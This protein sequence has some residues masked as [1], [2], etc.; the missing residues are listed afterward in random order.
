MQFQLSLDSSLPEQREIL[1]VRL[2]DKLIDNLDADDRLYPDGQYGLISADVCGNLGVEGF[3][4]VF[5]FGVGQFVE[6]G[7]SLLRV[8]VVDMLHRYFSFYS[9]FVEMGDF[10]L[11]QFRGYPR[12]AKRKNWFIVLKKSIE[13]ISESANA[14]E[15]VGFPLF[16][17]HFLVEQKLGQHCL[18]FKRFFFHNAQQRSRVRCFEED[19]LLFLYGSRKSLLHEFFHGVIHIRAVQFRV[20]SNLDDGREAVFEQRNVDF[21]LVGAQPCLDKRFL[22]HFIKGWRE[23]I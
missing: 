1:L 3:G 22:E 19:R 15:Q 12:D 4:Q 20:V 7:Y 13:D 5:C 8:E 6:E 17:S 11:H 2:S 14:F 23:N 16:S 18:D 10:V 21:C 9:L